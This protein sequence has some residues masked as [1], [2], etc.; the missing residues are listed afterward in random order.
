MFSDPTFWVALAFIA[1]I[2]VAIYFKLPGM[3]AKQLD[4]RSAQI[5]QDLEDAQ[6]LREEAQA[7]YA[8]YKR[9]TE[10]AT[11]EAADIVAQAKSDS[12]EMV[13]EAKAA[14]EVALERRKNPC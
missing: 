14:L 13:K 1:F 9:K 8:D 12:E 3:I 6:R 4:D 10:N 2:G 7:L 11:K 5:A